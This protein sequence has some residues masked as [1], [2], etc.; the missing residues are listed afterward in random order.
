ML[1]IYDTVR[2]VLLVKNEVVGVVEAQCLLDEIYSLIV[3]DVPEARV[4]D[5]SDPAWL[6]ECARPGKEE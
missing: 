3:G 6:Q 5:D 1:S 4:L 2:K